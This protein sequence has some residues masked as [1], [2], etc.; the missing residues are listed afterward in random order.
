MIDKK[1]I[2]WNRIDTDDLKGEM[3]VGPAATTGNHTKSVTLAKVCFLVTAKTHA[4]HLAIT[5]AK[6]N[7]RGMF[8]TFVDSRSCIQ[9][10][11][12]STPTNLKVR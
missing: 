8:A 5:S 3:G 12:K 4:I 1:Y 9:A 11:Q 6:I 10:I 2:I 7:S